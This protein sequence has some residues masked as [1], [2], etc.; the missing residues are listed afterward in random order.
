MMHVFACDVLVF[1]C[2]IWYY[3]GRGFACDNAHHVA[4]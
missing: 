1:T 4:G 2:A 3:G